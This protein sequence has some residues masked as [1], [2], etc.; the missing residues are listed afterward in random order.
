MGG[1]DDKV[2]G[3]Q[4]EPRLHYLKGSIRPIIYFRFTRRLEVTDSQVR[5][6]P[7]DAIGR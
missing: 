2:E 1:H 3:L 6:P 4:S 5:R 7:T